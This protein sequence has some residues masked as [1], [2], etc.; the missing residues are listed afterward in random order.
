MT[1][2]ISG[3]ERKDV[4]PIGAITKHYGSL[5]DKHSSVDKSKHTV[6]VKE[7]KKESQKLGTADTALRMSSALSFSY[8][9]MPTEGPTRAVDSGLIDKSLQE[10]ALSLTVVIDQI[11]AV[12][13]SLGLASDSSVQGLS[14]TW[15]MISADVDSY[16]KNATDSYNKM[17]SD[18][19]SNTEN[20]AKCGIVNAV[21]EIVAAVVAIVV[22]AAQIATGGLSVTGVA[23]II[24]GVAL[25]ADGATKLGA[26]SEL[27]AHPGKHNEFARNMMANGIF[28]PLGEKAGI[29]QLVFQMVIMLVTLGTSGPAILA[30]DGAALISRFGPILGK[31]LTYAV[32]VGFVGNTIVELTGQSLQ[33]HKIATSDLKKDAQN[34]D[35]S[36][37]GMD[38]T[39]ALGMGIMGIIL[40][41]V[42]E[43][44][45]GSAMRSSK[46][47]KE[48]TA[49]LE[50]GLMMVFGL[51]M[52]V[53]GARMTAKLMK[54]PTGAPAQPSMIMQMLDSKAPAIAEFLRSFNKSSGPGSQSS[55]TFGQMMQQMNAVVSA[56]FAIRGAQDGGLALFTGIATDAQVQDFADLVL[57]DQGHRA[58]SDTN[59]EMLAVQQATTDAI[60][61]NVGSVVEVLKDAISSISSAIAAAGNMGPGREG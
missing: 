61:Q 1:N 2:P 49:A 58:Q 56:A 44:G 38:I 51:A 9:P 30:S 57:I 12:V 17:I 52:N 10:I 50:M 23:S 4:D 11:A 26:A 29:A 25:L 6:G 31:I 41:A 60:Q 20:A 39:S 5:S 54:N 24:A 3:I 22:G 15:K 37:Q 42:L 8:M 33:M 18:M 16:E 13:K 27:L 48:G 21:L 59:T 35:A 36:A 55:I 40:W 47:G 46:L 53:M 43:K 14:S 28:A 45:A 7:K 32:K 19:I 34:K